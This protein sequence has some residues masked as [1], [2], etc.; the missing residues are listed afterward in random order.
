MKEINDM[1]EEL[2]ES[3]AD[4]RDGDRDR[5]RDRDRVECCCPGELN[6]NFRHCSVWIDNHNAECPHCDRKSYS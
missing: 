1:G 4:Y 5:Y 2:K 3:M 6:F